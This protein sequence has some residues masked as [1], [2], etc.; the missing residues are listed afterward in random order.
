MTRAAKRR[1]RQEPP[2]REPVA[3]TASVIVLGAVVLICAGMLVPPLWTALVQSWQFRPIG[4]EC[5]TLKNAVAGRPATTSWPPAQ[6]D[7]PPKAR[8]RP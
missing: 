3:I 4:Q 2:G 6:H 8:M 7:I 1:I 5:S